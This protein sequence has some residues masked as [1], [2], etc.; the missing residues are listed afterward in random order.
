MRERERETSAGT[1]LTEVL[2]SCKGFRDLLGSLEAPWDR[3]LEPAFLLK[4]WLFASS[5]LLGEY[6]GKLDGSHA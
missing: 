6:F 3:F 1:K 2:D 4:P 5:S